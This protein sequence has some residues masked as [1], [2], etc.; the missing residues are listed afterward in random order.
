M[1]YY[2]SA[3]LGDKM[4]EQYLN[5]Q[6][7]DSDP[8]YLQ[9]QCYEYL[10][11]LM[12]PMKSNKWGLLHASGS[13][14]YRQRSPFAHES[15]DADY[16][17]AQADLKSFPPESQ[18]SFFSGPCS[19]HNNVSPTDDHSWDDWFTPQPVSNTAT[20]SLFSELWDGDCGIVDSYRTN[21]LFPL[22]N[23]DLGDPNIDPSLESS[24]SLL[25]PLGSVNSPNQPSEQALRVA[26]NPKRPDN[27]TQLH[28]D[29]QDFLEY[30]GMYTNQAGSTSKV[31]DL[32]IY[33][34]YDLVHGELSYPV[35]IHV[36]QPIERPS[37]SSIMRQN[38]FA[39][40]S[41]FWSQSES[42]QKKV[43]PLDNWPLNTSQAL[44][45]TSHK[46][47][48]QLLTQHG[49]ITKKRTRTCSHCMQSLHNIAQCPLQPCRHCH[50]MG[51]VSAVCAVRRRKNMDHRRDATRK[52]RQ[53][54][55]DLKFWKPSSG[56]KTEGT[57]PQTASSESV[58][59][60]L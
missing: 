28:F 37:T 56:I 27:G 57:P 22:P 48:T 52:R 33:S 6:S 5:L 59:Q 55:R 7:P 11:P 50:Q 36:P 45:E 42:L 38:K 14:P 1:S 4:D 40:P 46:P 47:K 17:P 29:S 32:G 43:P 15:N 8:R 54:A 31:K 12:E 2:N 19:L 41:E 53:M 51:H 9:G 30:G 58:K 60:R 34:Q 39:S 44:S 24:T 26:D 21:D 49:T 25:P 3:S 18:N 16:K 23:S 35:S 10:S 20:N 13:G